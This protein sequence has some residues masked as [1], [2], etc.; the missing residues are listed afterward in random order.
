M[1]I[2]IKQ[3]AISWN[4]FFILCFWQFWSIQSNSIYVNTIVLSEHNNYDEGFALKWPHNKI[5]KTWGKRKAMSSLQL[6]VIKD[7]EKSIFPHCL[8]CY[9]H[10]SC[11]R[12]QTFFFLVPMLLEVSVHAHVQAINYSP[13]PVV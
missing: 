7:T 2:K 3:N 13:S 5:N 1:V 10:G 4:H 12:F 11:K 8:E 9:L 6:Y